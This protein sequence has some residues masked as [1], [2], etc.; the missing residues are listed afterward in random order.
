MRKIPE[1]PVRYHDFDLVL[2]PGGARRIRRKIAPLTE[3]AR[4][5]QW[6]VLSSRL[7]PAPRPLRQHRELGE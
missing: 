4:F 5:F 2:H 3:A 7:V 1:H 6:T